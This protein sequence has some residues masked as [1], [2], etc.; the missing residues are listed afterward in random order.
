MYFS[1][2]FF[3]HL[4]YEMSD[5]KR[6]VH[7]APCHTTIEYEVPPN[8]LLDLLAFDTEMEKS[9]FFRSSLMRVSGKSSNYNGAAFNPKWGAVCDAVRAGQLIADDLHDFIMEIWPYIQPPGGQRWQVE[10][11]QELIR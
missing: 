11:F 3:I 10:Q 8:P 2:T 4:H 9:H 5:T 6:L 7:F 1:D